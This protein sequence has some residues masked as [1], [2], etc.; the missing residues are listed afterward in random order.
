MQFAGAVRPPAASFYG[1][2]IVA[3]LRLLEYAVFLLSGIALVLG[4]PGTM[5]WTFFAYCLFSLPNVAISLNETL[6]PPAVYALY[7]SSFV[8]LGASASGFLLLFALL[9]PEDR[10]KQPWRLWGLWI[11]GAATAALMALFT[12][13]DVQTAW[14]VSRA[15]FGT[16]GH[17][18]AAGTVIVV[19]A[20]LATMQRHERAR[21]GWAAF[22]II[23]GAI[24]NNLR[25]VS[26]LPGSAGTIAAMLT[27]VMPVALMYAILRRHVIDVRF[28]I[29][30]TVVYATITTIVVGLIGVVD[31]ATS[32][33]LHEARAAMAIEA[34]V[35]IGLGFVLHRTYRWLEYAVD[36]F[37]F[38]HKYEAESYLRRLA[39][40]LRV[41]Q[42]EEAVDNALVHDPYEKFDLT[43]AAL[44]RPRG[45]SYV[46]V[47]VVGWSEIDT[48]PFDRDHDVVRFLLTERTRL[49]IGDLRAYV[50]A[51]FR[52]HGGSPAVAVPIFQGDSLMAFVLYGIHRS[53]TKLDPDEIETLEHLCESAAQAYTG[54]ELSRYQAIA[55]ATALNLSS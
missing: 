13:A 33:Y 50:A 46:P 8:V 6:L 38:R 19:I 27:V 30:R 14:W 5:T 11:A 9:V 23:W 31:W 3:M 52:E 35:T 12:F 18:F 47:R 51:P 10:P 26:V 2:D 45:A 39:K 7:E 16:V 17:V 44:F 21:F 40:T 29:S 20:R 54:I 49:A 22:A 36:F 1:N 48:P 24:T 55:P 15:L 42:R 43:A 37:L 32:A 25:S 41:A 28:V 53:G 4:R 34:L